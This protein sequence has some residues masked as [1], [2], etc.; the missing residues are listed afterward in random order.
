MRYRWVVVLDYFRIVLL[1]GFALP[2]MAMYFDW[3]KD[4]TF[5]TE[6]RLNTIK[7]SAILFYIIVYVIEL[8]LKLKIKDNDIAV[9]KTKLHKYEQGT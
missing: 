4:S 5:F 1:L 2:V 3:F 9:L 6:E 8:K 7:N